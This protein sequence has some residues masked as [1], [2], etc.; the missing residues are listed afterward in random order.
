MHDVPPTHDVPPDKHHIYF[1]ET[2]PRSN[3]V[4]LELNHEENK[5]PTRWSAVILN[6]YPNKTFVPMQDEDEL[7]HHRVDIH[8]PKN[9][10]DSL[11]FSNLLFHN[12]HHTLHST[13]PAAAYQAMLDSL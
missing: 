3:H 4:I 2:D 13:L 1:P 7:R 12:K 6:I 5:P 10:G 9:N 8:I 11:T